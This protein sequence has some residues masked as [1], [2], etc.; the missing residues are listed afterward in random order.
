M[1][2]TGLFDLFETTREC[3]MYQKLITTEI[4]TELGVVFFCS[5]LEQLPKLINCL[6]VFVQQLCLNNDF[7]QNGYIWPNLPDIIL[8]V[9]RMNPTKFGNIVTI[10]FFLIKD[11]VLN[12]WQTDLKIKLLFWKS[13][14]PFFSSLTFI[15]GRG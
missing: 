9:I 1:I 5:F 8:Y 14:S 3:F 10:S 13:L 6:S 15:W 11:I 7:W 2:L 4:T 12:C